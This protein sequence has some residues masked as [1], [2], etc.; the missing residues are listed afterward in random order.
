MRI[1]V[2]DDSK[3]MCF[4]M[5]TLF[6]AEGFE[7]DSAES[8]AQA[9]ALADEHIPDMILVDHNM[10][11]MSGPEFLAELEVQNPEATKKPIFMMTGLADKP[12]TP[13]CVIKVLTKPVNISE[14]IQL[15]KKYQ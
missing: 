7:V 2:V 1:L 12:V 4:L 13:S 8:G 11:E 14:L 9:L 15:A 3:D 6:S 10:P 5:E